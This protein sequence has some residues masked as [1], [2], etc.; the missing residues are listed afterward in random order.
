MW[1]FWLEGSDVCTHRFFSPT[2]RRVNI[3]SEHLGIDMITSL[4]AAS[5]ANYSAKH[6]TVTNKGVRQLARL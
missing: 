2:R 4:P 1:E 6:I 5:D 3:D